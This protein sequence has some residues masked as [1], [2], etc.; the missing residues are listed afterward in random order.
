MPAHRWESSKHPLNVLS[1]AAI[2]SL[3]SSDGIPGSLLGQTKAEGRDDRS[4][5][6][7]RLVGLLVL[8]LLT[9]GLPKCS[10]I[11]IGLSIRDIPSILHNPNLYD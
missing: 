3:Y 11:Q 2:R 5:P 4:V 7:K 8:I 10:Q 6:L 1:N 9:H